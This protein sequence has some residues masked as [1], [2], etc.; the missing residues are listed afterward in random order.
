MTEL[1]LGIVVIVGIALGVVVFLLLLGM[2]CGA[3]DTLR[4]QREA[5]LRASRRIDFTHLTGEDIDWI[6]W[7]GERL[8]GERMVDGEGKEW[9]RM[10]DGWRCISRPKPPGGS[11]AG[12]PPPVHPDYNLID[13][14][15]P[16]RSVR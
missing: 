15:N 3:R 13:P 9:V 12:S 10:G 7:H 1:V 5:R 8:Y 2:F 16:G 6:E 11:G 4:A 14:P